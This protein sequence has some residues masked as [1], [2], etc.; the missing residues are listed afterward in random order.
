M[1]RKKPKIKSIPDLVEMRKAKEAAALAS[2]SA[3]APVAAPL[4]MRT[5]RAAVAPEAPEPPDAKLLSILR[6]PS[7]GPVEVAR[8]T[9]R[10]AAKRLASSVG[11]RE[12][13]SMKKSLEELRR[14]E[15]GYME[16]AKQRGTLIER[17]VAKAV[18]GQT[19]ARA[20]RALEL[21]EV[22]L[23]AKLEEWWS[24]GE[25]E[26]LGPEDRKRVARSWLAE[27]ALSVLGMNADEVEKMIASEIADRKAS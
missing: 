3:S 21:V 24:S 4:S 10:L 8:A 14:S 17:D 9:M 15:A 13:E 19:V 23:G 12:I 2:L 11:E 20:K 27:Q 18:I 26:K 25:M 7:A 16:L 22:K 1:P 5:V 6:D